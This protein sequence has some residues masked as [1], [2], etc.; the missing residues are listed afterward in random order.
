MRKVLIAADVTPL[1]SL[2]ALARFGV[3]EEEAKNA[4]SNSRLNERHKA[5]SALESE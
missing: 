4:V 1:A 2:T 5:A 3:A